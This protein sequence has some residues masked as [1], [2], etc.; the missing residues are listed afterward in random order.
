[1]RCTVPPVPALRGPSRSLPQVSC[2]TRRFRR[3]LLMPPPGL[4]R[5]TSRSRSDWPS[6][7]HPTITPCL[8]S[9][10]FH[11]SRLP[12]LNTRESPP[13]FWQYWCECDQPVTWTRPTL[14]FPATL[15][16]LI[17][18]DFETPHLRCSPTTTT[19]PVGSTLFFSV[20]VCE[21]PT[22]ECVPL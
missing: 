16:T 19:E 12:C 4:H 6:S 10:S 22:N 20:W 7:L 21:C 15:C 2:P 11:L 5:E 13:A 18:T 17:T 9:S 8:W 3:P 1:M 14:P